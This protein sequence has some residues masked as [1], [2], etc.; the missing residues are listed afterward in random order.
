MTPSDKPTRDKLK[1]ALVN[2]SQARRELLELDRERTA[3]RLDKIESQ[4]KSIG[5]NAERTADQQIK[6]LL[7]G[8]REA[9][10]T[11]TNTNKKD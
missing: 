5:A 11:K 9:K 10:P 3:R 6:L 2:Q 7:E 4:I 8:S 1:Q